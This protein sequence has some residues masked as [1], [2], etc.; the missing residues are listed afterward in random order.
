MV[1]GCCDVVLSKKD[2]SQYAEC[3][4]GDENRTG[5]D[6]AFLRVIEKSLS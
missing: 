5:V 3:L 4:V 1:G 2:V 6:D